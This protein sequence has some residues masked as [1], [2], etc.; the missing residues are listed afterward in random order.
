M[1]CYRDMSFCSA[2]PD[3]CKNDK[4]PRA[5]TNEERER[6]RRWW[7]NDNVPVAFSDFSEDC[8]DKVT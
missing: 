3:R 2:Y 4:C 8:R 5:F 6:A 1:L 7:G